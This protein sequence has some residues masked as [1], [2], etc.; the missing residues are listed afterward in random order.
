MPH[1][2]LTNTLLVAG[3]AEGSRLLTQKR[4]A[5]PE[6]RR[7]PDD[8][9]GGASSRY[10]GGGVG[11]LGEGLW[12]TSLSSPAADHCCADTRA[13]HRTMAELLVLP[14]L[15]LPLTPV[16]AI[17]PPQRRWGRGWGF[18][19][20]VVRVGPSVAFGSELSCLWDQVPRLDGRQQQ[21]QQ[22]LVPSAAATTNV[23]WLSAVQ[24]GGKGILRSEQRRRHNSSTGAAV[25]W[26][27]GNTGRRG[28]DHNELPRN[29]RWQR[30]Q[31][32]PVN[33][34]PNTR[35]GDHCAS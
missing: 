6:Q 13:Q 12:V 30:G 23:E 34:W 9:N 29:H 25:H 22:Q 4:R 27:S 15:L 31:G 5:H 26:H 20:E 11:E 24:F 8:C 2:V 32:H 21:Q 14:Q 1:R 28:R 18:V 33:V 3:N 17:R 16:S 19:S 35:H 7:K 10:G